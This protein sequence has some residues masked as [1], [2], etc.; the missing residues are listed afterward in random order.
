MEQWECFLG[1]LWI[2]GSVDTA[3]FFLV[4]ALVIK[5]LGRRMSLYNKHF[6]VMIIASTSTRPYSLYFRIHL[7]AKYNNNS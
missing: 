6:F 7:Y 4:S 3:I 2:W 1:N 5:V